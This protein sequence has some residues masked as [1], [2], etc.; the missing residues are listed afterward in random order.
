MNYKIVQ[1]KLGSCQKQ[2]GFWMN[3]PVAYLVKWSVKINTFSMFP[4]LGSI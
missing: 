3:G 1:Q 2:S 4:L